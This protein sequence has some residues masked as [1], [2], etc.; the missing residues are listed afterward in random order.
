VLRKAG[1]SVT[2]PRSVLL[3]TTPPQPRVLEVG[4]ET[5]P[6]PELLPRPDGQ[7]VQIKFEAPGEKAEVDIWRTSPAVRRVT[8]VHAEVDDDGIGTA[9]WSGRRRGK[10]VAPGTFVALVASR[11]RAGNRGL[12]VPGLEDGLRPRLQPHGNGGI[13]VRYLAAQPPSYPVRAGKDIV[14]GVDARSE[15]WR[16]SLRRVGGT[17]ARRGRRTKGGP[18]TLRA[19]NGESGLFLFEANTATKRTA[20]PVPI[21]GRR[22]ERVLVVLPAGTWQGRN[23]VDDDGDGLPNLLELGTP[24]GIERV[25]GGTG[26]PEGLTEN[27]APL[28]VALDHAGHRYD[29]T[30]DV[31]LAAGRGPALDK[32]KGVLIAGDAVWLAEDV[33]AKLRTF[34]A[35]GGVLASFGTG[36]LRREVRQ[37]TT[38]LLDPSAEA[39]ED[40][41]GARLGTVVRDR[42]PLTIF[43]DDPRLA[44]FEG[45]PG[46]FPRV[47]AW[48]PTERAGSESHELSSAVTPD[49]RKVILAVRF[50]KGIV[51]RPGIPG[52]ATRVRTDRASS[53][54]LGRIWT[55]LRAG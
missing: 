54:L 28:L 38:R 4:P 9:T 55:L 16:W 43:E 39:R 51:I 24:V 49:T 11:D 46:R 37:E 17:A 10:R 33:R 7:P 26:L 23:A 44:L 31:A 32:H 30:T 8:G 22:D 12:S 19:P 42:V 20:V 1:R 47:E 13:T 50:G 45:G 14:V 34:V 29:L 53:E 3:D 6:G 52:F 5:G 40:L 15:P 18:F 21:D 48:E 41:F 36:S 27:E 2:S 25:Y 35:N